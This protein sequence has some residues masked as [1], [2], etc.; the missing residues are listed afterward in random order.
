[1]EKARC[2]WIDMAKGLGIILVVCGHIQFR[3]EWLNIWLCSFHMPLFFFLAGLTINT[4]KYQS[5]I[6]LAKVKFGQIMIPYFIFAV[7]LWTWD[8]V[9]QLLPSGGGINLSQTAKSFLGIFLQIRGSSFGP[10]AWFIPCIFCCYLIAYVIMHIAKERKWLAGGMGLA[11]LAVGYCY[12]EFIDIKLPWGMDAAVVASFFMILGAVLKDKLMNDNFGQTKGFI[13]A[14][15][16]ALGVNVVFAYLNYVALG[17]TVGMWSNH[18]GNLFYF[19]GGAISG[20]VF[21][22]C[23]A[24]LIRCT[25]IQDIGIHSI[26]YYGLHIILVEALAYVLWR[27]PGISYQVV[28]FVVCTMEVIL[29]LVI[30]KCVFPLYDRLY[31]Y[32]HQHYKKMIRNEK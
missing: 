1:M 18:Y 22:I 9:K 10:G 7:A 14:A 31:Q 2:M 12:C 16:V 25:V 28:A 5:V 24:R 11:C 32:I 19:T 15:A 20:I 26:F 17:R 29:V 27:I 23:I 8:V 4:K 30:L 21:I 13:A 3:P 6:S